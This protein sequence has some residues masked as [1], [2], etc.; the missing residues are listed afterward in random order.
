[1]LR[2]H[3][4][5][6]AFVMNLSS[7][8]M[9]EF[10]LIAASF[11][12]SSCD[13]SNTQD[14]LPPSAIVDEASSSIS[15]PL[16]EPDSQSL[17]FWQSQ[18]NLLTTARKQAKTLQKQIDAL[19]NEPSESALEQCKA[20][21]LRLVDAVEPLALI[22]YLAGGIQSAAWQ[23]VARN[24]DFIAQ[25]P[26]Q[27]GYLDDDGH[28]GKT[29]L[30]F[31]LDTA[32]TAEVLRQQHGLTQAEDATL[33]VYPIGLL[34]FGPKG[35]RS[36]NEFLAISVLSDQDR[37]MGFENVSELA[38]NRRRELLR[39]Q[40]QLILENI[41]DLSA[42]WKRR[43]RNS[44]INA[45]NQGSYSEQRHRYLAAA[46]ELVTRQV[47][48]LRTMPEDQRT[49]PEDQR[50]MPEDQIGES[51]DYDLWL[52]S[53]RN[54][55]WRAQLQGL[56]LWLA[57]FELSNLTSLTK[58]LQASLS[59]LSD[60]EI[61]AP[62]PISSAAATLVYPTATNRYTTTNSYP[63][64]SSSSSTS[65]LGESNTPDQVLPAADIEQT[66]T[67]LEE[68]FSSLALQL[69]QTIEKFSA[70]STK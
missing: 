17:S 33:G 3:R 44:A 6:K 15:L 26:A 61:C 68:Q 45:L 46:L 9:V 59:T 67:A 29:G 8:R 51:E 53:L 14:D 62:I 32:I 63:V 4:L 19:L 58:S 39:L 35:H 16:V 1:M 52:C 34:L 13:S 36:A 30:I 20:Q 55:R 7:R 48:E 40:A 42:N 37:E 27:L 57:P 12:V 28:H 60:E 43:D 66:K 50:T 24:F 38:T 23:N 65:A 21:W 54:R 5:L 69:K 22:G 10:A 49:I 56:D 41:A 11:A 31:D 64:T 70:I 47:F 25:W 18:Q 2:R